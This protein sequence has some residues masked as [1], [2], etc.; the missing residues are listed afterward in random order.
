MDF[1]EVRMAHVRRSTLWFT[2]TSPSLLP[3][4]PTP[5]SPLIPPLTSHN[6]SS[7]STIPY[8]H[9]PPPS[10][11]T[12]E[13]KFQS[14]HRPFSQILQRYCNHKDFI[15]RNVITV[16]VSR[17]TLIQIKSTQRYSL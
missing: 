15:G 14:I 7:L 16:L 2:L 4:T 8:Q 11:D 17:F 3:L 9:P 13:I 6:H 1:L 12:N 5:H 10:T